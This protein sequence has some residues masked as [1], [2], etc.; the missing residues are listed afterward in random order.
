MDG[1]EYALTRAGIQA[2]IDTVNARGG[3]NVRVTADV[4]SDGVSLLLKSNTM[5][6][7]ANHRF[8]V[9]PTG[10]PDTLVD[11]DTNTVVSNSSTILADANPYT[12]QVQ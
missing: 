12:N 11:C 3:G 6:D 4:V 2:A 9:P 8:K 1:A 5:V 7:F 10:D